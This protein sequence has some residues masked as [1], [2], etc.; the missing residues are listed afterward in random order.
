MEPV[1]G[2]ARSQ[3]LQSLLPTLDRPGDQ[4]GW[5]LAHHEIGEA[6]VTSDRAAAVVV[7]SRFAVV[8]GEARPEIG[9]LLYER[10]FVGMMFGATVDADVLPAIA[11][12]PEPDVST[13][14]RIVTESHDLNEYGGFPE[15]PITLHRVSPELDHLVL[16]SPGN[17]VF[18]LWHRPSDAPFT[19]CGLSSE[20]ELLG[21]GGSYAMSPHFVEIAA[22]ADPIAAGAELVAAAGDELLRA[23]LQAGYG[24]SSTILISNDSARRFAAGAGWQTV[25]EQRIASFHA[26]PAG[27]GRAWIRAG[28]R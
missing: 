10:V 8:Y 16:T 12:V 28:G 14:T 24:I 25:A 26:P 3:L 22:W 21:V 13:I 5:Q 18:E 1:A 27:S 23:P 17:W 9:N 7:T 20:G 11:D 19:L 4:V 2:D 6:F 15:G